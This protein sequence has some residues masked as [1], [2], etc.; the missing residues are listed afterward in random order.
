MVRITSTGAGVVLVSCDLTND[1]MAD[2]SFDSAR[3]LYA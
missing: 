2:L 1:S 3:I